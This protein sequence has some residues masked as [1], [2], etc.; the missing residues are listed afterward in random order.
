MPSH[1]I[2]GNHPL[3][4][5][6]YPYS[7]HNQCGNLYQRTILMDQS[8]SPSSLGHQPTAGGQIYASSSRPNS[9]AT[10]ANVAS[11]ACQP[12]A[13][14]APVLYLA[15]SHPTAASTTLHIDIP[16][17]NCDTTDYCQLIDDDNTI[18]MDVMVTGDET[19]TGCSPGD[20]AGFACKDRPY[21]GASGVGSKMM[22]DSAHH[23][24]RAIGLNCTDNCPRLSKV[25]LLLN[26]LLFASSLAYVQN[27]LTTNLFCSSNVVP[28]ERYR[29]FGPVEAT[30]Q[31]HLPCLITAL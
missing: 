16:L 18:L 29:F 19:A 2:V 23:H 14:S 5:Q 1:R 17:T 13:S 31:D 20:S 3:H 4:Q 30:W 24:Q 9:V 15:H 10:S 11:T 26:D 28:T 27:I 8:M 22:Y 21:A 6:H 25:I 12:P 7:V